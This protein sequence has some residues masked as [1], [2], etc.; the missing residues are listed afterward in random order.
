[1]ASDEIWNH[2]KRYRVVRENKLSDIGYLKR[3]IRAHAHV[4]RTANL[5]E[6]PRNIRFWS[7]VEIA[8][9][10]RTRVKTNA[11]RKVI[12][13]NESERR[14]DWV[15][16]VENARS[17][18]PIS[19]DVAVAI[20]QLT[21]FRTACDASRPRNA[22]FVSPSL[23]T[24][25]RAWKN[26]TSDRTIFIKRVVRSCAHYEVVWFVVVSLLLLRSCVSSKV[27]FSFISF[28]S[29]ASLMVV[30]CLFYWPIL[31]SLLV[32]IYV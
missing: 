24:E 26:I 19:T 17:S 2:V 3:R 29:R 22:I 27:A 5:R 32:H 20:C 1:M 4:G 28:V 25:Q 10:K 18:Y 7:R 30:F 31:L 8:Q 21:I 16:S 13:Q 15:V 14:S 11:K 23:S 6:R 12:L 9:T